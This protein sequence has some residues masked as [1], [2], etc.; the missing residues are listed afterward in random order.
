MTA[1]LKARVAARREVIV[2]RA[3]GIPRHARR[4]CRHLDQAV[5]LVPAFAGGMVLGALFPIRRKSRRDQAVAQ[6]QKR[7][8]PLF[9]LIDTL[10]RLAML[11]VTVRRLRHQQP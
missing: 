4:L 11:L 10:G 1:S 2:A 9:G 7:S 8:Y 6:P 5:R 3:P